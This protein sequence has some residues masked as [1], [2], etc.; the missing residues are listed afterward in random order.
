MQD[1]RFIAR[2]KLLV[3]GKKRLGY[4]S[5]ICH[6]AVLRVVHSI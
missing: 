2:V 3:C 6:I 4:Q 5:S 1:R